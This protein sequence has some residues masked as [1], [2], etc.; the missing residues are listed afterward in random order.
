MTDYETFKL[1]TGRS[2]IP[3]DLFW[4]TADGQTLKPSYMKTDHIKCCLNGLYDGR[5]C[6]TNES[7]RAQYIGVFEYELS[8]RKWWRRLLR[9]IGVYL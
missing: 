9:K 3:H 4:Y 5:F 2:T 8:K 1:L 7:R 6:T